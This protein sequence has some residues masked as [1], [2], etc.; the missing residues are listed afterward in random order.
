MDR[1][2]KTVEMLKPEITALVK[3]I[4]DNSEFLAAVKAE[5]EK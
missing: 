5:F 2:L 4:H 1:V 3:A